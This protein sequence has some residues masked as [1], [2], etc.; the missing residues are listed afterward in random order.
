MG[1]AVY[2]NKLPPI[3][4]DNME[5]TTDIEAPGIPKDCSSYSGVFCLVKNIWM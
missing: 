2:P 1:N 4:L 5:A 3:E